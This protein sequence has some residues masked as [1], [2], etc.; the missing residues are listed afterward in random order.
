MKYLLGGGRSTK[1][2]AKDTSKSKS[3]SRPRPN[4][5]S[6]FNPS[7]SQ[8]EPDS[9][10]GPANTHQAPGPPTASYLDDEDTSIVPSH[11]PRPEQSESECEST[12]LLQHTT[13][14]TNQGIP[15]VG[16]GIS[17]FWHEWQC[18]RLGRG[19][20]PDM[21]MHWFWGGLLREAVWWGML[22]GGPRGWWASWRG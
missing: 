12:P 13:R 8:S 19:V 1:S 15:L 5:R 3:R 22:G 16:A 2:K 6:R 14:N 10:S 7:N 18:S 21:R 17:T 11:L 4:S 9:R 20:E